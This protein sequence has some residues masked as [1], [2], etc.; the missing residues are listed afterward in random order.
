MKTRK[1]NQ[2]QSLII[3]LKFLNTKNYFLHD[4][5]FKNIQCRFVKG[6]KI[7]YKYNA[8]N[9]KIIF[10]N[11]CFVISTAI[12]QLIKK[13]KHIYISNFVSLLNNL[14]LKKNL[15]YKSGLLVLLT[16]QTNTS[17]KTNNQIKIPG[18]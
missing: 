13:T 8:Y 2:S 18:L 7:I 3:N 6:L 15:T 1:I 10:F 16:A 5:K 14:D 4:L 9:K 17:K 11:S 12:K